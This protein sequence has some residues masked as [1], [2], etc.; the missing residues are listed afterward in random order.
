MSS[1]YE[2]MEET[3]TE[4]KPTV[5]INSALKSEDQRLAYINHA[6][7]VASERFDADKLCVAS[8]LYVLKAVE[9]RH[10]LH[11]QRHQSSQHT[12]HRRNSSSDLCLHPYTTKE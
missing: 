12:S 7:M 1:V 4:K 5:K 2:D 8:S 9:A 11:Q 3:V 10:D 6:K